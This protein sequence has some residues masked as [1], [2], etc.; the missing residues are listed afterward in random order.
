MTDRGRIYGLD[1]L[2]VEAMRRKCDEIRAHQYSSG[3]VTGAVSKFLKGRDKATARQISVS[4]RIR[5][6]DVRQ[7]IGRLVELGKVERDGELWEDSVVSGQRF[8]AAYRWIGDD[9]TK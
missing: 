5:I 1:R 4:V 7:A 3:E 8:A 6:P 9:G 2:E